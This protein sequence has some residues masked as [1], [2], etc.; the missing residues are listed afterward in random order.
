MFTTNVSGS[1][2]NANT[3]VLRYLPG[4]LSNRHP[5]E[6]RRR[7]ASYTIFEK[8]I[9]N[10]THLPMYNDEFYHQN[11]WLKS[12]HSIYIIVLGDSRELWKNLWSVSG[13]RNISL[14]RIQKPPGFD[15]SRPL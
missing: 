1:Q 5:P 9:E 11:K 10:K 8:K 4:V 7:I 3:A 12:R 15:L 13:V 2:K 14:I 6:I